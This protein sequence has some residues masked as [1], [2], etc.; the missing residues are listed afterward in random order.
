MSDP[1]REFREE[2]TNRIQQNRDNKYLRA[3]TREFNKISN[4]LKYSYNFQWL[5][6]PII[7][8]PQDMIA[9]QEIIF[10]VKPDLIIETGI[11][12]GGSLIFYASILALLDMS[13]AIEGDVMLDARVSSRLVIGVDIDVRPH[14][15]LA[16]EAHPMASRIQMVEGSSLDKA[17]IDEVHQLAASHKK[18]M[19]C[20]DSNHTHDHVL[21]ELESYASLTT[22][23]SYC[24]VF[25]TI[26]DE[27]PRTMYRNR[28]WGPGNSPKSAV[29]EYLKVH[30]EFEIDRSIEDKLQITVAP[31]GYLRRVA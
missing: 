17:I 29:V 15:R 21:A 6:R 27:L 22:R 26:V 24:V 28:P 31:D 9:L 8:Y 7:Q 30:S 20:L 14:N 2:V 4:E 23:G 18:I 16:I 25:D 5:G 11:A 10:S 3:A 12:R 19:V 13:D 1:H